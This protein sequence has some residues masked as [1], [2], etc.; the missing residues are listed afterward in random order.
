M[1]GQGWSASFRTMIID[2]ESP[3]P[4]HRQIANDL[5]RQIEDG[6]IPPGRAIPSMIQLEERYGVARDTIRKATRTLKEE[7]LLETVNG[8]GIFVRPR[9]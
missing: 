8:L 9:E 5:R 4:P 1:A 6:T 2:R 7:G 3:V